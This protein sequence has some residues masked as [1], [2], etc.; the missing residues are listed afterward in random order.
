M[1]REGEAGLGKVLNEAGVGGGRVWISSAALPPASSSAAT[2]PLA[3]TRSPTPREFL[4]TSSPAFCFDPL[5]LLALPGFFGSV[6]QLGYLMAVECSEFP[7][8]KAAQ[9]KATHGS[10]TQSTC[11]ISAPE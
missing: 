3:L 4:S 10:F 11:V 5:G 1:I 6:T 8:V 2:H 9:I 7:T